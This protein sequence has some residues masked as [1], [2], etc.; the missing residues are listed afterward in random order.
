METK[1][2][3]NTIKDLT[4]AIGMLKDQTK[5]LEDFLNTCL[6]QQFYIENSKIIDD[7]MPYSISDIKEFDESFCRDFLSRYISKNSSIE[8]LIADTI[9]DGESD[10]DVLHRL[11]IFI[12][13]E[14]LKIVKFKLEIRG[15]ETETDELFDDYIKEYNSTEKFDARQKN[16]E[17]MKDDIDSEQ[18]DDRRHE[19]ETKFDILNSA[20]N[21]DFILNRLTDKEVENI[22]HIFFNTEKSAYTINRYKKSMHMHHLNPDMYTKF[23]NIEEYFCG[24]D[25][26]QYN[27]LFLFIYMRFVAYHKPNDKASKIFVQSINTALTNLMYHKFNSP[28]YEEKMIN[29]IKAVDDRFAAYKD[30]FEDDNIMNPRNPINM[31]RRKKHDYERR[32]EIKN[33]MSKFNINIDDF[34]HKSVSDL[35]EILDNEIIK[36]MENQVKE[37]EEL[38]GIDDNSDVNEVFK[39]LDDSEDKDDAHDSEFKTIE[40]M[41]DNIE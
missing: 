19:M 29:F 16:L 28:E 31:M 4:E 37:Y 34:D 15:F 2:S 32:E 27:N 10:D 6:H 13:S 25:Y 17:K 23:F 12:K 39:D 14:Y 1:T 26:Y 22:V 7:L 35:Q 21:L 36:I 30:K 8:K 3:I 20:F 40:G 11:L 33:A 38:N 18:D 9:K 24:E 5:N 41:T